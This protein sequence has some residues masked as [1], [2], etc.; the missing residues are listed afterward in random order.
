MRLRHEN[1]EQLMGSGF[2]VWLTGL[3]GAGMPTIAHQ[4]ER[5]LQ[6]RA[7]AAGGAAS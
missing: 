3:S 4:L 2:T 5:E 6:A 7:S 1:R